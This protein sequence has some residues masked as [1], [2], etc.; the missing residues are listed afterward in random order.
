MTW[1]LVAALMLVP[2]A[3]SAQETQHK[4]YLSAATDRPSF[5]AFES[6]L[7]AEAEKHPAAVRYVYFEYS[8][9]GDAAEYEEMGKYG[10]LVTA[11][12]SHHAGELPLVA[13]K[14]G[15]HRLRC[16]G[17]IDRTARED[18]A[19]TKAFGIHRVDHS[20]WCLSQP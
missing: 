10:L 19:V 6:R 16:I 18:T 2:L 5:A 14:A 11:A 1:R 12:F 13:M 20:T 9:P 17:Q 8:M 4:F 3:A 15:D 7:A